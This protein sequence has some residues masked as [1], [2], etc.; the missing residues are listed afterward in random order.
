LNLVS[1]RLVNMKGGK[2][3]FQQK[4]TE[5][6]FLNALAID[7]IKSTTTIM[8]LVGCSRSTTKNMLYKLLNEGKVQK[9]EIEGNGYGWRKIDGD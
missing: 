7:S 2:T 5:D 1:D 4:F 8:N 9:I 3:R 6:M